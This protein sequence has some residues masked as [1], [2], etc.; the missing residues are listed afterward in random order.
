MNQTGIICGFLP[1]GLY[2]LGRYQ[3]RWLLIVQ[4]VVPENGAFHLLKALVYEK[5]DAKQSLHL[6]AK[7]H[8]VFVP[9]L[10]SAAGELQRWR[11]YEYKI[12]K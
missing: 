7:T 5:T 11:K 9:S 4:N 12:Q 3:A 8:G 1:K 6:T 2:K 10:R